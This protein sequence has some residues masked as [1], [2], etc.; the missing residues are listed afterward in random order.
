MMP[1]VAA[2][3]SQTLPELPMEAARSEARAEAVD[4]PMMPAVAATLPMKA[5]QSEARAEAVDNPMMPAMA[6]TTCHTVP[7]LPMEAAQSEARAEAV[8]NP[9]PAVAATTSQRVPELPMEAAQSEAR[10]EAAADDLEWG[11]NEG[12]SAVYSPRDVPSATDV[13]SDSEDEA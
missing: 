8:D 7:E 10:A 6:A 12:G 4:D 9:T 1:P 11:E 2:T 13:P 5:A 3:T